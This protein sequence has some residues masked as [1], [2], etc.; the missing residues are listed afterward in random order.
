MILG[1]N[2]YKIVYTPTIAPG[3]VTHSN[4]ARMIGTSYAAYYWK[5]FPI[6]VKPVT[7]NV[8]Y[9]LHSHKIYFAKDPE[10][11]TDEAAKSLLK[12]IKQNPDIKEVDVLLGPEELGISFLTILSAMVRGKFYPVTIKNINLVIYMLGILLLFFSL[13]QVKRYFLSIVLPLVL[14]FH[15]SLLGIFGGTVHS[16]PGIFSMVYLENHIIYPLLALIIISAIYI[17]FLFDCKLSTCSYWLRVGMSLVLLCFF[18][19]IRGL[20]LPI[21]GSIFFALLVYNPENLSFK[22]VIWKNL[23]KAVLVVVCFFAFKGLVIFGLKQFQFYSAKKLNLPLSQEQIAKSDFSHAIVHSLWCGL[24]DF[25][26]D[27]GYEWNDRAA[28]KFAIDR[29]EILRKGERDQIEKCRF[30]AVFRRYYTFGLREDYTFSD[31]FFAANRYNKIIG[32]KVFADISGDILWYLKILGKRISRIAM[33]FGEAKV[34]LL[35]MIFVLFIFFSRDKQIYQKYGKLLI[36]M[37]VLITIPVFI[38]SGLFINFFLGPFLL[39]VF[40][41][42]K[43][44]NFSYNKLGSNVKKCF[45]KIG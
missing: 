2:L 28:Y 21:I 33:A 13:L 9:D 31:V 11:F 23:I 22:K 32:D 17:P 1:F 5:V 39:E 45:I 41:C 18:V 43:L 14:M 38:F 3:G 35:L 42:E 4:L 24:G 16:S 12:R 7:E 6:V 20:A 36:F 10:M 26:S 25:G 34:I 29:D 19:L 8:P 15:P 44:L 27:K 30:G 40:V 37:S